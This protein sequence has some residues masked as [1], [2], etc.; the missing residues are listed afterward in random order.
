MSKFNVNDEEKEREYDGKLVH[1][2]THKPTTRTAS[3][4]ASTQCTEKHS[5]V[6]S[7]RTNDQKGAIVLTMEREGEKA[8]E[9]QVKGRRR[10][11]MWPGE[12]GE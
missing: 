9:E 3:T 4:T 10:V 11:Q 1:A 5:G 12:W 8:I 7:R 6:S 2:N